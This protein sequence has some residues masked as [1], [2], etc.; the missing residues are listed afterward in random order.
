MRLFVLM[1]VGATIV[2]AQD[3]SGHAPPLPVRVA[4]HQILPNVALPVGKWDVEFANG[5]KEV[6]TIGNGG[7]STVVEPQRCS[8]G[9][10]VV[11]GGSVVITFNDD[12]IVR[13]TA[14]GK[15]YVVEHWFPA[16]QVL[17]TTPVLGIAKRAQ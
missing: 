16:S 7:E 12:R 8:N 9:M 11:K 4:G 2:A 14:V 10:A 5:V 3:S 17:V 13:W 6:C 15:S 1:V